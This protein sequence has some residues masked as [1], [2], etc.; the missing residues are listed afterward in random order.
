MRISKKIKLSVYTPHLI[1]FIFVVFY[2]LFYI[3]INF[4]IIYSSFIYID[5]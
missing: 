4:F 2:T 1:S 3:N 5:K